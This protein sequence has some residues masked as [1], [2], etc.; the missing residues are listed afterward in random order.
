LYP[1]NPDAVNEELCE[2]ILRDSLDPGAINVMISGS[3]LPPPRTANELLGADYGSAKRGGEGMFKGPV[4]VAQ[5]MLDPLND[6]KTRAKMFGELR[7]GIT[8]APIDAG[9]CPHDEAPSEVAEAMH[10]WMRLQQSTK[11]VNTSMTS[12]I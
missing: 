2:G 6:A 7:G 3:K 11:V 10:K 5:G 1:T 12:K 9:H 8:V 4:L